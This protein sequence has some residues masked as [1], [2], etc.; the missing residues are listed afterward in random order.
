MGCPFSQA[1]M[2][3]LGDIGSLDD[4]LAV[5]SGGGDDGIISGDVFGLL[6]NLDPNPA[7]FEIFEIG[8]DLD[9]GLLVQ[10][11]KGVSDGVV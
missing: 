1:V 8:W 6:L 9:L 4:A 5:N 2:E 11:F 10:Q 7:M 3:L